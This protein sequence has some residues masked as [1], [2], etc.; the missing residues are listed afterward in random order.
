MFEYN[1]ENGGISFF[2]DVRIYDVSVIAKSAYMFID[3][4]YIFL[5]Y[6][7]ENKIKVSLLAKEG[8]EPD[9]DLLYKNF[10]NELL[11]QKIRYDVSCETKNIRE[12]ILGRALYSTCLET[13]SKILGS[14]VPEDE[15]LELSDEQDLDKI[16]VDWFG[17]NYEN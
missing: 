11:Q 17:E 9:Y 12:I 14:N 4:W 16:A 5:D 13:D 6:D 2:I 15:P 8:I 1:K 3:D 10:I 7:N